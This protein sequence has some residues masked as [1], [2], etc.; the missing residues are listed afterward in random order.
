[1]ADDTAAE[2][3]FTDFPEFGVSFYERAAR[4]VDFTVLCRHAIH[5][6]TGMPRLVEALEGVRSFSNRNKANKARDGESSKIEHAEMLAGIARSEIESDFEVLHGIN[7]VLLWGALESAMRDFLVSWLIRHPVARQAE[8]ISKLRIRIG[9]YEGLSENDR[10]RYIIGLLEREYGSYL[11]PGISRFTQ[12]L[13]LFKII[14]DIDDSLKDHLLEMSA[15]RNVLVHRAGVADQR[16]VE[17]CPNARWKLDDVIQVSSKDL[18]DY[19][20]SIYEFLVS[21]A[22]AA[23]SVDYFRPV[24]V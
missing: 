7:V 18:P 12:L 1:M 8:A 19:L 6:T 17:L 3:D 13:H 4:L 20:E 24:E 21:V 14:P 15:V 10:M 9:E 22:V 2:F 16:F 23:R 5:S 11:R